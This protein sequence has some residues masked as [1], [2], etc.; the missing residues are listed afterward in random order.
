[1]T[2]KLS[3]KNTINKI[4][5]LY[6]DLPKYRRNLLKHVYYNV[7]ERF[8][9]FFGRSVNVYFFIFATY[10]NY[11]IMKR[12][13]C[14]S[15][16]FFSIFFNLSAYDF[17]FTQIDGR[18]G[19]S[20]N[21]VKAILQDSYGFMWFGTRNR[22]NRY[23]G[24]NLKQFD[25]YDPNLQRG[26]N[27]VSSLYEDI[28]KILWVGTDRGIFLFDPIKEAFTFF[29]HK[30]ENGIGITDWIADIQGDTDNNIWIVCPNQGVFK[31]IKNE[32]RL[33]HYTVVE[34][35][36]I[37]VSTPQCITIEKNGK[38][39]IGT[40]GS[41]I[42]LYNKQKDDFT[43]YLGDS[44]G[45]NYLSG[46]N[47]YTI[48]YDNDYI[49][50]GVH[51]SKLLKL[52]KRRNLIVDMNISEIDYKIIRDVHVF[53]DNE[54]WVAT[55]AGIFV[56]DEKHNT[57]HHSEEDPSNPYALSDVLTEKIYQDKEGGIWIGCKFGGINYLPNRLNK[58]EKYFPTKDNTVI[59]SKHIREIKE[60]KNGNIL[61]GTEDAGVMLF[62]P[63]KKEF[64]P[65]NNLLYKK[66][67]AIFPRD[68]EVWVG[69][70][71]NGLDKIDN[72]NNTVVHYTAE[73][74]GLDE[75]SVTALCEDRYGRIWL[76]NVWGVFL[77]DKGDKKFKRMDIFGLNYTFDIM[78]DSDG[79]I[80][81][82][83]M[84]NGVY[85]YNPKD[86]E[87]F[88]FTHNGESTL[89]SN[90]VSSITE[91][92]QG[93]IWFA[94][95]RGGICVY[96][97]EKKMFSTYSIKEGLPDDIAYKIVEDKNHNLWFGTN[98][99]LV[100]FNPV[101]KAIRIFTK[102]DGLLSDQFNY[103]SALYS[104]ANKL[105]FGCVDGLIVF[106]PEEFKEDKYIPPVYITKFF[107]SNVEV[108]P[109]SPNSPLENSIIHTSQIVLTHNQSN[110]GFNFVALNFKASQS[111]LYAYK[112]EN[113]DDDWIYTRNN[114]SASYAKL[115]PG[116][117]TFKV[118][119]SNNDGIWS[120]DVRSINIEILPP[121]WAS[122]FAIIVYILLFLI[123][124]YLILRYS[125]KKYKKRNQEKQKLFEI[126]KEKELYETKVNFF[127]EI[128]HEI[129]T[130]VTLIN[131]PLETIMETEIADKKVRH[132]LEIIENNTK[133]LLN[134]IN[135]LLDF[136]K[137][138]SDKFPLHYSQIDLDQFV[139]EVKKR[140][141]REWVIGKKEF[142]VICNSVG[143]HITADKDAL[144]KIFDNMLSNAIKYSYKQIEMEISL[145][146]TYLTVKVSND[147]E[148]I[149][150]E[151]KDKIFEPFFQIN[152]TFGENSGSGIGLS[153][154]RSLAELHGGYL[155]YKINNDL[156]TFTLK[157]P[158][159]LE[160]EEE[161]EEETDNSSHQNILSK[162]Y[163]PTILIVEDNRD[164]LKFIV[165]SLSDDYIV[166]KAVN[167]IEA[168]KVIASVN[169]DII[170]SDV[171]MP[172]M[173]GFE[174]CDYIKSSSEYNHIIF[175]LLTARNDLESKIKGLELGSDAYIEKPFSPHYLKTSITSLINNRQ[176]E[177]EIF[178]KKPF[179]PMIDN[180]IG[181]GD[182]DF[183]NKVVE[184]LNENISDPNFNVEQLTEVLLMS[185]S[186][187]HRRI[188]TI[189]GMSPLEF[190]RIIRMQKAAQLIHEGTFR[191][192]EICY[193][194]GIT[195]PSYFIRL[196]QQHYGMTPKEY[197]M[198]CNN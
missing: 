45:N 42:Y 71:K 60:D 126:E 72:K 29:D 150:D 151:F 20:H 37:S 40:N 110:L 55:E 162:K 57:I 6:R 134:L 31:Y 112:M 80:W 103:K 11:S 194:V 93:R 171:M 4:Y 118:I 108:D 196:F 73:E 197:E 99:G 137:V 186:S 105:Y 39:W 9:L 44:D 120:E 185:R 168:Q 149:K 111:N 62:D 102:N 36:R 182:N 22:L 89:S 52:D 21:N 107:I 106:D 51:E 41:G 87:I 77:A 63:I 26:N 147:G 139:E 38:V 119:A 136:R 5:C 174:L 121:W 13:I 85:Q 180:S 157:I 84:G 100:R 155:L 48:S 146:K 161:N 76:G 176:R 133:H 181:K 32:N 78:E 50:I 148:L 153:L 81:V 61:I 75:E 164:M 173:D 58:F 96:N 90:S 98:Q 195:T 15:F 144:T 158:V 140:Y 169:V 191:I 190:M 125:L 66:T 184:V 25:C 91:D 59:S 79:Y 178:K 2:K 1:L 135:Q 152:K 187:F 10:I 172:E 86:E 16:L 129:R 123:I 115:P 43:Q 131:G 88:H 30:T 109:S 64:W 47:I 132:N 35:L 179:L 183:I 82:A 143:D 156:N 70:F 116:K 154:A 24:I 141:E 117:Y 54:I 27:N 65:K 28:N 53:N 189:T 97:K 122:I 175:I 114:H 163:C 49:I 19:L 138:D 145:D 127:T 8:L 46:K 166:K 159:N 94:T 170:I 192:N 167:G 113:I 198:Q 101:T 69:Y 56:I 193:L 130:P 92:H 67:L 83:T 177:M 68:K 160:A 188:K 3:V 17:Y 33:V 95:D 12:L 18:S 124:S 142:K 7:N 104:S 34:N 23:D 165:D 14:F 74:M 128:A